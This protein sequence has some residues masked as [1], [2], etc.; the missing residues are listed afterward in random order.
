MNSHKNGNHMINDNTYFLYLL[1]GKGLKTT[2][3]IKNSII[4]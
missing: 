3:Y 1:E 4:Y 2:K